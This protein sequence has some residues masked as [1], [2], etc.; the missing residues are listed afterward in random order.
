MK[1]CLLL[2]SLILIFFHLTYAQNE[3]TNYLE[4]N[5]IYHLSEF[6]YNKNNICTY[7]DSVFC[8]IQYNST[9]TKDT[10]FFI[11]MNVFTKEKN[12]DTIII[13]NLSTLQ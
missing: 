9:T 5:A 1:K 3:I 2:K 7:F 4:V 6:S 10:I 12:Y 13:K 11:R 8:G